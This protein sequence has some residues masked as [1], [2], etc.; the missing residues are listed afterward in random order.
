MRSV[1]FQH[2]RA[3][4]NFAQIEAAFPAS[5]RWTLHTCDHIV[6]RNPDRAK[7]IMIAVLVEDDLSFVDGVRARPLLWI[8][9]C[10]SCRIRGRTAQNHQMLRVEIDPVGAGGKM[11]RAISKSKRHVYVTAVPCATAWEADAKGLSQGRSSKDC[12]GVLKS[13]RFSWPY[14]L[15][16][17]PSF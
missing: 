7:I 6:R 12:Y 11:L 5:L 8:S 17:R 2:R 1:Q 14:F 15:F 16:G 9:H 13:M 10:E 3:L 4:S